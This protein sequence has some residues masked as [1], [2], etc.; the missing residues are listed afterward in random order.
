MLLYECVCTDNTPQEKCTVL[1]Y[2]KNYLEG[3]DILQFDTQKH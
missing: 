3:K 2:Q 1:P